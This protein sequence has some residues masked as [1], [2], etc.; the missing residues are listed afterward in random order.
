MKKNNLKENRG[1]VTIFTLLIF[2]FVI[3]V[4]S[5]VVIDA[6]FIYS[7]RKQMITSADAAALAGAKE[8]EKTLVADSTTSIASTKI[9]AINIAKSIALKNGAEGEAEVT[10]EKMNVKIEDGT[11]DYRDVIKVK[12][13]SNEKLKLFRFID[14]FN[15]NVVGS[16]IATWGYPQKVTAG[17]ILPLYTTPEMFLESKTL[18]SGKMTFNDDLFPNQRGYIYLDPAWNG[19]DII[20]KAIKGNPTKI[21]LE[22]NTEFEGKA[23]ISQSAINAVES[24]MK[25]AQS[26]STSNAR[27]E[28]MFGLVPIATLS[29]TQ[30][31]QTFFVVNSFAVY[32]IIDVMTS[33]NTG[34]SEALLGSDYTRIGVGKTYNSSEN[35]GNDF[36]KGTIYGNFTGE[37]RELEIIMQKGDQDGNI[38]TIESGTTYS[39]LIQ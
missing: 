27:R 39:K 24:R 9:K 22:L 33:T 4:F 38:I 7:R 17:Q 36:E 31:N 6:G 15:M 30:G 11:L 32:E 23:G 5:A 26:L 8:M 28:H 35:D 34:S 19:Q 12:V 25:T 37:I 1:S 3:L 16:A 18:K 29:R 21:T 10:I 13:S 2:M 20:N 14:K